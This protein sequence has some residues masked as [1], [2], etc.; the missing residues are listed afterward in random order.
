MNWEAIGAIGEVVGSIAVIVT[1]IYLATQIRQNTRSVQSAAID[2]T[3]NVSIA[4]R[5]SIYTSAELSNIWNRGMADPKSLDDDERLR[6]RL[7]LHNVIWG[8]W[9]Q[10]EQAELTGVSG[11]VWQST[12]PILRRIIG[13]PGGKWFWSGYKHEFAESFVQE[14]DGIVGRS[15]EDE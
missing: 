6:F 5:Q 15:S 1:L 8:L 13:S 4:T 12:K 7:A 14:V 2:T 9:S 3:A 10:Y 11:Q